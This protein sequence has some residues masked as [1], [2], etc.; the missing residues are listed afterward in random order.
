M[1]WKGLDITQIRTRSLLLVLKVPNSIW[2][3]RVSQGP[4]F[5][6]TIYLLWAAVAIS[7]PMWL[8]LLVVKT[9]TLKIFIL[10]AAMWITTVIQAK[11]MGKCGR[12]ISLALVHLRRVG[13]P[14]EQIHLR[15][16]R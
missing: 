3:R 12:S 9:R 16:P 13:L 4:S 6:R 11:M 1:I 14:P 8:I 7:V 10:P 15:L 2:E 5:V